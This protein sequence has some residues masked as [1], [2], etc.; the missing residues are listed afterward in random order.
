MPELQ[1]VVHGRM[2]QPLRQAYMHGRAALPL[3]LQAT[4]GAT[5][6][7]LQLADAHAKKDPSSANRTSTTGVLPLRLHAEPADAYIMGG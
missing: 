5:T 7:P 3:W 4:H 6:L 2:A 1:A